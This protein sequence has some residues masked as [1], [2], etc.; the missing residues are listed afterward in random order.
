MDIS[1]TGTEYLPDCWED[2]ERMGYLFSRF[3]ENRQ[4]NPRDWD[5]KMKFWS[6]L[7]LKYGQTQRTLLFSMEDLTQRFKR[8]GVVPQCIGAVI[9]EMNRKGQMISE[10]D[11][12]VGTTWLSWGVDTFV[13]RPWRWTSATFF[14]QTNEPPTGIFVSSEL[15]KEFGEALLKRHH[16]AVHCDSTDHIVEYSAFKKK[17]S[18]LCKDDASF[19]LILIHLQKRKRVLI[20]TDDNTKI[21]KF[22]SRGQKAV[23]PVTSVELG[24]L[25][26]KHTI[27]SMQLTIEKLSRAI[28]QEDKETRQYLR[29]G[30]KNS[31]KS[32]LKRKKMAQKKLSSTESMLDALRQ[33][34]EKLESVESDKMVL[35]AYRYGAKALK[36]TF[37]DNGLTPESVDDTISD[38]QEVMEMCNEIDDTMVRGNRSIDETV[39]FGAEIDQDLLEQELESLISGDLDVSMATTPSKS[40]EERKSMAKDTSGTMLDLPDVPLESPA[41]LDSSFQKESIPKSEMAL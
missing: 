24:T 2:D 41:D 32:A 30:K 19:D 9:K 18:D 12:K 34:Q 1:D 33:L 8:K 22:A 40:T 11:L 16:E 26:L 27:N 7:V 14:Q 3:R 21:I 4:V 10:E 23:T 28:E 5:N 29:K 15:L 39:S 35:D 17:C 25:R 38:V 31:A 36:K 20:T 13:R 6:E 37:D